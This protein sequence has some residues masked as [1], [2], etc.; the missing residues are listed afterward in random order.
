MKKLLLGALMCLSALFAC[1]QAPTRFQIQGIT[2]DT[3]S[4]PLGSATVM[5]LQRKDS[6]LVNFTRSNDKGVFVLRNVK[7]GDY[8]LK[9]SFVG[10]IPFQK[11]IVFGDKELIDLGT[12]EMKAITKE[13]FEVVVKTARA[14]LSIKG[15]TIEYNAA[16]F[17][18]PPGSTV[19]DLLRKL[20]GVQIDQDGNIVAQGQQVRKVT[21]DGKRFFG[22][23]PKMATKNLPAEAITKV[24]IF[25]DKSEQAKVTGVDDGKKEKTVNLELKDGFKK[26]GFGK[27]TAGLGADGNNSRGARGEIKG[28]YNKFDDKNQFSLIG[29]TN[30]TNQT[31]M[32]WDDYQDFRGSGS[33]NSWNDNGD[34]GFGGGGGRF[35]MI[36]GEDDGGLNIPVGGGRGQGYSNNVAAGIN[37]NYNGKKTK[38]NSSYY[39]NSTRQV[40]DA[41]RSR[42]NFLTNGSF[43]SQEESSQINFIG[44]HRLSFRY[45]QMIDSTNTII[46]TNNSRLNGGNTSLNSL[47][48]YFQAGNFKSNETTIKNATDVDKMETSNTLIYRWKAKSKKGR[49][50]AASGSYGYVQ[51]DGI[52]DQNSLNLF[53]SATSANDVIRRALDLTNNTNSQVNELKSS[54]LFVEPVSKRV[55]W[56]TFLNL[57]RRGNFVDRDAFDLAQE[58]G[59]RIPVD[60]L[61][62]YFKNDITYARI[63]SS[64][65][66]TYKGFNISGGLAVQRFGLDGKF[67]LGQNPSSFINVNRTFVAWLPNA[68]LNY[69]LKNNRYLWSGYDVSV[70]QPNVRDLQPVIDNSNPLYIRQ[71]NPDLLPSV[72]HSLNF[73]YNM[74]NPASFTNLG[75]NLFYS[76]NVNQIIYNQQVDPRTLVTVTTP[77]NIS[78]GQSVGAWMNF[79]FPLKKTKSNLSVNANPNFSRNLTYINGVL[80][81]TNND[82]Y[83]FGMRLDLTPSDNFTFFANANWGVTNSRFSVNTSQNMKIINHTYGGTMNIKLPKDFFINSNLDY[84]I[85][86]NNRFNLDQRLPIMNASIYKILGK[87]KKAEI[88]LSVYD[89]FNKNLGISQFANQ[90]FVSQEKVQ[91]LARYGMLTFTYNMR[92]MNTTLK[93]RGGFF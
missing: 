32:S 37:Y 54:L 75:L 84:R 40:L 29:L 45:E 24:Q 30:N 41:L 90:N 42:E 43:K 48:Q 91:T 21:V 31:G 39:Y 22:D 66:Y 27:V 20:P 36:G 77:T 14:P 17:K 10:Y 7:K 65:R 72:N 64:L 74:F 52:A 19:E 8:L 49:N 60:T 2:A 35:F 56:E 12:L 55:F 86:V 51:N 28:N 87:A 67:A 73:G 34:F 6:S 15:D 47:Q 1:A 76:Y 18:V 79:G 44:N 69:D 80:N 63:G 50:F 16:S 68:S 89:V 82:S 59:R 46:F 62:S 92:G 70:N 9:I 4:G 23:D 88:R 13:L 3:S 57:S 81:Q 85:Y 5:L 26:G 25:N 11:D 38:V 71:G 58:S 53:Y 78:G 33:F 83:R 93:R 61:S